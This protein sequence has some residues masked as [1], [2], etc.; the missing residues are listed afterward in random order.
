[1]AHCLNDLNNLGNGLGDVNKRE[2]L[3]ESKARKLEGRT[4]QPDFIVSAINQLET[5][6][7][8][9]VGE[10]TLNVKMKFQQEEYLL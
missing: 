4:R 5:S 1:L 7:T 3:K 10:V 2:D 6:G 8:L 9:F